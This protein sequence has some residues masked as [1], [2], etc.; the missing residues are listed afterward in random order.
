MNVADDVLAP[1]EAQLMAYNAQDLDG[2][3]AA[4]SEDIRFFKPPQAEPI[5]V[6]HEAFR[7]IYEQGAFK[8]R[9]PWQIELGGRIA[10]GN[11]VVDWE[12]VSDDSGLGFEA[13]AVFEVIQGRIATLWLYSPA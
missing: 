6:G 7:A 5:A 8:R 3:V 2:F 4:F 12:K 9:P 13:L 1:V 11:L 10:C